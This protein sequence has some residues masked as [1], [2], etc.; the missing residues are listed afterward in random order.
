LIK[1]VYFIFFLLFYTFS[2][3]AQN[4]ISRDNIVNLLQ[5]Y[6]VID[7]SNPIYIC[8]N[9]EVYNLFVTVLINKNMYSP[10]Q[11][12]TLRIET[13]R[14]LYTNAS[15]GYEDTLDEIRVNMRRKLLYMTLAL[16]SPD[17]DKFY[18]FVNCA[19]VILDN[20][21]EIPFYFKRLNQDYVL[22]N[23]LKILMLMDSE[24]D[25]SIII[26]YELNKLFEYIHANIEF[27]DDFFD[28]LYDF[29]ND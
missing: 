21:K 6:S 19:E 26:R 10:E 22:L 15:Y 13:F 5:K 4:G 7:E 16:L 18:Y 1:N 11:R 12:E 25:K 20:L 8:N 17:E 23:L 3:G 27:Q 2:L 9:S 24:Y 14:I 29:F 28:D